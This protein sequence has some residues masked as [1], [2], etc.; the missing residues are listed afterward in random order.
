MVAPMLTLRIG[1]GVVFS[2]SQVRSQRV[3]RV[4]WRE[5]H[6]QDRL[7][8]LRCRLLLRPVHLQLVLALL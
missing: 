2:L 6:L 5:V 1:S 7:P 8:L 4:R 3:L